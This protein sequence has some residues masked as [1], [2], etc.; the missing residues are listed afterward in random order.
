MGEAS[1]ASVIPIAILVAGTALHA[2]GA[3]GTRASR[4]R[5]L[6]TP[7]APRRIRSR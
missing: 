5:A 4:A 7:S 2:S 1:K 6:G 3:A